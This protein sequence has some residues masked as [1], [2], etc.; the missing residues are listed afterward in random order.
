VRFRLG[1]TVAVFQYDTGSY[2]PG[3][4]CL[5]ILLDESTLADDDPRNI[6]DEQ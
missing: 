4:F 1:W 5:N 6:D 2:Q 3:V